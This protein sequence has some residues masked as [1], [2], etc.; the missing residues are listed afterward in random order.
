[1][2]IRFHL[3]IREQYVYVPMDMQ[4]SICSVV[5]VIHLFSFVYLL[6]ITIYLLKNAAFG[7]WRHDRS[8]ETNY[9]TPV[10]KMRGCVEALILPSLYLLF[11]FS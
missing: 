1:M 3:N 10:K 4:F 7:L 5:F 8:N 11:H 6:I 9:T 2:C